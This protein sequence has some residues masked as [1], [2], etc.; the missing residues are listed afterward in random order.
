MALKKDGKMAIFWPK[1]WVNHFEKMSIF[2]L[3]S[4]CCFYSLKTRFFDLEYRKTHFSGL[5]CL[6]KKFGKMAIVWQKQWVNPFKKKLNF[7]SFWTCCFYSRQNRFFVLECDKTDFAGLYCLKK[8]MEK[9]T[10]FWPKPWFNPF[11]KI[12]ISRL[13]K[14]LVFTA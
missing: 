9:L 8:K 7:T 14:L 11:E 6:E 3:F 1:P 10:L 13:F 4:T 2:R 12:S 5:Y